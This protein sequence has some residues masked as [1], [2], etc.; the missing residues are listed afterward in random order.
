[1]L[2]EEKVFA[3]EKFFADSSLSIRR[4]FVDKF[5]AMCRWARRSSTKTVMKSN[6]LSLLTQHRFFSICQIFTKERKFAKRIFRK[7]NDFCSKLLKCPLVKNYQT[8][9]AVLE[10]AKDIQCQYQ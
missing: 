8:F 1:M 9:K 7:S 10:L 6:C 4:D 2:D 5:F 3:G